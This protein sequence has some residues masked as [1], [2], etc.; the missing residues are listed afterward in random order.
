M[1]VQSF[2][3][4]A[5]LVAVQAEKERDRIAVATLD[6]TVTYARLQ[7]L[8]TNCALHM[9]RHGIDRSSCI[10][11]D[12][13]HPLI[14]VSLILACSLVGCSWLYATQSA[15]DQT[16]IRITHALHD[17]VRRYKG[18]GEIVAVTPNWS[19]P[20]PGSSSRRRQAF[21][22]YA[23]PDDTW[24]I[25]QSSGTTGIPKFMAFSEALNWKRTTDMLARLVPPNAVM[26]SL[27]PPLSPPGI[28]WMLRV[29]AAGG[30]TIFGYFRDFSHRIGVDCVF[31]SPSQL[32]GLIDGMPP[33]KV[34]IATAIC[35]GAAT[36]KP[37]F[38]RMLQYFDTVR[39]VYASSEAAIVSMD[40]VTDAGAP[41]GGAPGGEALGGE[42]LGNH[43]SVGAPLPGV[44]LQIVDADGVCQPVGGE[45]IVRIGTERLVPGYIGDPQAMADMF[46]DGW[47]Y[48]GDLGFLAASGKL[49]VTGRANDQLN[50]GG[51]KINPEL[52]DEVLRAL[53]NLKDGACF[54]A[55]TADGVA[56]LAVALVLVDK[57]DLP[58]AAQAVFAAIRARLG[59]GRTPGIFYF[60]NSIPRNPNGKLTRHLLVEA[61][62]DQ[63]VIHIARS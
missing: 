34:R 7:V 49:Y 2:Y 38:T 61:V 15:Q 16:S 50:I 1:S 33:P 28:G 40:V 4:L 39:Y 12:I 3:N 23:T 37:F 63:P 52:V 59:A 62:R 6:E 22:G 31:G 51:V 53:P 20:P 13:E 10:A 11:L 46:R 25:A 36:S 47:F 27:F 42:A 55:P 48:P 14:A 9:K 21:E 44:S 57:Q 24:M 45:G 30:T 19:V 17:G 18:G 29:L 58:A 35:A 26:V 5:N 43:V 54:T 32:I 8:V 60:V 41:G 56:R